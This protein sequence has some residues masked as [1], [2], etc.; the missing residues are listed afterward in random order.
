MAEVHTVF[1]QIEAPKGNFRGRVVEGCY[2]VDDGK[3]ILTNR[4]GEPVQDDT[5]KNYEQRLAE[6]DNPKQIAGILTKKLRKALRGG[7]ALP[8]GFSGPINYPKTG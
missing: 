6:G 7:N 3:V 2:I 8:S 1:V 4:R 5:G